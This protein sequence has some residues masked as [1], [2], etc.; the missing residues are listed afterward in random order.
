LKVV[1]L[2]YVDDYLLPVGLTDVHVD[3]HGKYSARL[4]SR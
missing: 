3:V 4:G 2:G 1:E